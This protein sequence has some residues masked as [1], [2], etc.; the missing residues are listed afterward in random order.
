MD[1]IEGNLCAANSHVPFLD[2]QGLDIFHH[3]TFPL[4]F[5]GK[6]ICHSVPKTYTLSSSLRVNTSNVHC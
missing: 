3:A 6:L 4:S 1:S 2:L 5:P